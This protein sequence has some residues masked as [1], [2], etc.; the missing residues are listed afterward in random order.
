MRYVTDSTWD[1]STRDGS[2][3][4][5]GSPLRV[6]RLSG[7]GSRVADDIE[8]GLDVHESKLVERLLDAGA[9]HPDH[10]GDVSR[11]SL[12]DV[13][14]VTPQLGGDVV[15]G[16]DVTVDDGS[17]PP[18]ESATIRLDTNRGPGAARNAGRAAVETE[19]VAFVDADVTLPGSSWLNDLLPHFDDPRVGLA[20]PR[21]VGDPASSLDLGSEPARVRSG[22][23]VSY[24]PAA[25]IVVR[26][27]AFDDVGGFDEMLRVGEDVDFVW[28]LDQAGWGCRYE[29]RSVVHH[30]PRATLSAR[31]RQQVG[32]GTSAAPLA[33]RHPRALAPFRSNGWMAGGWAACVLG[34]PALGGAL[35]AANVAVVAR[36]LPEVPRA[37][38]ARLTLDAHVAGL[39]QLAA[40]IRRV[41]WPI[42]LVAAVL[43][44]RA[45]WV[46]LAA[47]ALG[48]R[49][50]HLDAAYGWGVWRGM[51]DHRSWRPIVPEISS[52]SPTPRQ[53][54][55]A[56]ERGQRPAATGR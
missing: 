55:R 35:A 44:K 13:T 4:L 33:L 29:P 24:V 45:R 2:T 1:R 46:T 14:I 50:T 51:I 20:A 32:Y 22:S 36:A 21:V 3:L 15:P 17:R 6:F 49:S 30:E 5:A 16:R 19:L 53:R 12:H 23:R 8:A 10:A 26:V 43:S 25:A 27:T 42:A 48:P 40:T 56:G 7:A 28:R 47:V 34:H 54:R 39:R 38:L 11:L 41:W 9:I 52:W 37:R 18:I 31:L